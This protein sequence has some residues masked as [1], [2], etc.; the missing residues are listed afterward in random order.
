MRP[1]KSGHAPCPGR[2]AGLAQRIP[3]CLRLRRG[4]L[5]SSTYCINGG[6]EPFDHLIGHPLPAEEIALPSFLEVGEWL[7]QEVL[8]LPAG[9]SDDLVDFRFP[10][11]GV[12]EAFGGQHDPLLRGGG[13]GHDLGFLLL[14]D[15]V[16]VLPVGPGCD[17]AQLEGA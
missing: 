17:E 10:D 6:V 2:R 1:A 15:A 12:L 3:A 11:Q 8:F 4:S 14:D 13:N 16:D 9:D 7:G 5:A